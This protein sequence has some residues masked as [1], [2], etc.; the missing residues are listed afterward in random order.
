MFIKCEDFPASFENVVD[1]LR[2]E[3]CKK[4]EC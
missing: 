3:I 2:N 4:M 1:F